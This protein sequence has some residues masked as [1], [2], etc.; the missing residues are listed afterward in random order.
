MLLGMITKTKADIAWPDGACRTTAHRTSDLPWT[1]APQRR[2]PVPRDIQSILPHKID[3]SDIQYAPN[4]H[5]VLSMKCSR[6][7]LVCRPGVG[8]SSIGAPSDSST[9]LGKLD[10]HT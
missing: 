3:F 7:V 2:S 6:M 1:V 8:S 9:K 5:K 4:L 10:I